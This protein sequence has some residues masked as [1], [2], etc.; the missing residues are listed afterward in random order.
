MISVDMLSSPHE[1]VP[2]IERCPYRKVDLKPMLG[3]SCKSSK[4]K[5]EV[6]V[7]SLLIPDEFRQD[8]VGSER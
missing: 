7:R 6:A 3:V 2:A 5:V 1:F 4:I 8:C